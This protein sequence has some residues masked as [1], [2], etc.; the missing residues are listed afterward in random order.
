MCNKK[1]GVPITCLF[2]HPAK[3][4]TRQDSAVYCSVVL[5]EISFQSSNKLKMF[6]AGKTA[7]ILRHLCSYGL[8]SSWALGNPNKRVHL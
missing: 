4:K 8:F 5:E 7:H 2:L 6:L 1:F 3:T